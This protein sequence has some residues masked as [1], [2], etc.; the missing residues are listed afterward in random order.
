[1]NMIL[2][3]Y[4]QLSAKTAGQEEPYLSITAILVPTKEMT[5]RLL[6]KQAFIERA[7]KTILKFPPSRVMF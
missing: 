5:Q 6:C 2:N 3:R 7:Y 4:T 1:M